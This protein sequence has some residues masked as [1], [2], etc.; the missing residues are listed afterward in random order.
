MPDGQH[1]KS[2]SCLCGAVRYEVT[3]ALKQVIGCHCTMC[4][5]QAGHFLAFTAAWSDE[6][7]LTEERGLKW[8]RSSDDSRRGFCG[9]CGS[10]LFFATDDSDR[11]SITAGSIEGPTGLGTAAHIFVADK[12]DYYH[13]DNGA[14]QHSQGGDQVPM[15]PKAERRAP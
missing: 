12:G 9:E 13:L 10:V 15:P 11:I 14:S 3:G 7:A 5:K 4:R 6:F 8:Y 2:G 1:P